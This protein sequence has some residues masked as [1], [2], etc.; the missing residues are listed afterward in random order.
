[1]L[2]EEQFFSSINN[3][4]SEISNPMTD[5]IGQTCHLILQHP[6][7]NGCDPM[8]FLLQPDPRS[9]NAG[10]VVQL[11][12]ETASDGTSTS[13]VFFTVILADDLVN[14]D[15]T[16]HAENRL[17]MYAALIEYLQQPDSLLLGFGG[18]W[19]TNLEAIGHVST[20]LHYGDY[21]LMACQFTNK[22]AYFPAA[23]P[24]RFYTSIWD[25]TLTWS[26]SYWR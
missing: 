6:L 4:K 11:Q 12:R 15:G 24:L 18:G 13:K 3:Q 1:L 2:I 14:P 16:L 21:S 26:T 20:E 9:P 17:E 10:P 5:V 19:L 8:G 25:G 22:A 23:D 7:V